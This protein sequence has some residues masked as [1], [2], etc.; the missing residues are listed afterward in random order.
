MKTA[1]A[2]QNL[3]AKMGHAIIGETEFLGEITLEVRKE[4]LK[5]ALAFLKQ[6]PEPGYEVLMDL[7]GV[8]YL[9]PRK[10]P[11]SFIGFIIRRTSKG[12]ASLSG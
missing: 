9:E 2:V 7:T 12:S 10:G 3:K 4:N 11:K 1:E 5:E 8:D 6:T